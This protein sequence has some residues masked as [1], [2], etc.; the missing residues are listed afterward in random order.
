[1]KTEVMS[2]S[3]FLHR[4]EEPF[5]VKIERHFRKYGTVYKIAGITVIL[6]AGFDASTFASTGIDREARKLYIELVKIGKWV[7]IFKG[8]IDIIKA[9]GDGD[10]ASAK[11]T[12]ITSLLTFLILLGLPY[13]MDKIGEIFDNISATTTTAPGGWE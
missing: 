8:A 3:E 4:K 11:K 12:F 2:I 6:L 10:N 7:I 5:S 1:M 9:L 13:G